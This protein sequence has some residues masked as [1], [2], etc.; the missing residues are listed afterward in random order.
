MIKREELIQKFNTGMSVLCAYIHLNNSCKLHDI[1][2]DAEF[3]IRDLLRIIF[4]WDIVNANSMIPDCPGYDL[5]SKRDKIIVQVTSTDRPDKVIDTLKTIGNMVQCDP[6]LAG[7]TLYFVILKIS[8]KESVNYKGRNGGYKC[9]PG[10]FFDQRKNIYDFSI[11]SKKVHSLSEVS[12]RE[13]IASLEKFM[14]ENSALFGP[15]EP[16]IPV[17]NNIDTIISEYAENFKEKLFRH[18]NKKDSRVTLKGVF[19]QPKIQEL[20]S[21]PQE[22]VSILGKFL[23][24]ETERRILFVEGDAACGKSSFISYLCYHYREQDEEGRGI[25][26]QGKLICIRLRDLEVDEKDRIIENN[27]AKYLGLSTFDEYRAEFH[28]HIVILDGADELSMLEGRLK[29][30]L[31]DIIKSIR[32]IFKKNKIIV[33]TRPQYIDY[34]KL[35]S[36]TFKFKE[37]RMQHFDRKMREAWIEKYEKCGETIPQ[38]TKEYILNVDKE[39][40]AGVADTPL[41]LYLLAACEMREELQWNIWALYHEIFTKAIIET[42]YDENFYSS[43]K[44]PIRESKEL[45]LEIVER[46]AFEIFKKSEK[47]QYFIESKDL[48]HIVSEF[49]LEP[50]YEKWIRKCCVLCAYWKSNE[51]KGVLEFYHNNIRDYF[52]CEYIYDKVK[53]FLLS[54]SEENIKGFLECMC[55]ILS[56]GEIAGSTWVET[57]LF[58]HERIRFEREVSEEE[59]D[60]KK[61]EKFFARVFSS[62]FCADTIWKYSYGRNNYQKIKYTVSNVLL[63][64]RVWQS[65]LGIRSQKNVFADTPEALADIAKSDILSDWS[66]IFRKR[67]PI[68]NDK[69]IFIGENCIFQNISFDRKYLEREDFEKSEFRGTSFEYSSLNMTNFRECK[70]G[71]QVSFAGTTLIGVDFSGAVLDHVSFVGAVLRECYFYNT[72]I[73]SGDFNGCTIESCVFAGTKLENVDW[74]CSKASKFDFGDVICD[75][76]CFNHINLSGRLIFNSI[77]TNCIIKR[78]NFKNANIRNSKMFGGSLENTKFVNTVFEKNEWENVNFTGVDFGKHDFG[79]AY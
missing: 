44:H 45:L 65:G 60:R 70:L 11:L 26:L 17:K 21:K 55:Q 38:E 78:G 39:K 51:K 19:V 74:S 5:I 12:D 37:V 61:A 57:L 23:W 34:K 7:Y 66:E 50:S 41:A 56:Y 30:S 54:D 2:I 32:K 33:T 48:D 36:E 49:D 20:N 76:C 14:N 6:E 29:S 73:I 15:F 28:N 75:N 79:E 25:F 77:F 1:N 27:I 62:V 13:K 16:K 43:S 3:F 46:I 8:A 40:V 9:P 67:I 31:E 59:Y 68:P 63:L 69:R 64:V 53:E 18:A 72:E 58:L 71:D 22:L 10:I 35:A 4:G 52:F 47:E 42:E 24:N